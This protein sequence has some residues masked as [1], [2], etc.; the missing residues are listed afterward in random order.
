MSAPA[1]NQN[2]AGIAGGHDL[3]QQWSH[4]GIRE[5][6]V[7]I[8]PKGGKSSVVSQQKSRL[9]G[10]RYIAKKMLRRSFSLAGRNYTSNSLRIFDSN[11]YFNYLPMWH[12]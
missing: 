7:A 6:L 3:L 1:C 12:T 8:L 9:V 10:L 2:Q 5:R 4:L 11:R